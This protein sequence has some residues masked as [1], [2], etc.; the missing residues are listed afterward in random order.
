MIFFW[1]N[2]VFIFRDATQSLGSRPLPNS[3]E[4]RHGSLSLSLSLSPFLS[5]ALARSLSLSLSRCS[6]GFHLALQ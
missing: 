6:R 4:R 3:V 5:L 2:N 1:G